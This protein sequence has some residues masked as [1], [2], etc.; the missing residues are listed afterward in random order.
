MSIEQARKKFGSQPLEPE[1]FKKGD[2]KTRGE[3][4]ADLVQ[5]RSLIGKPL[6]SIQQLLGAPDGYFENKGIPA[7]II[8]PETNKR[9]TWQ[10]VFFPDKDWKMVDEVKI[11]KNCCD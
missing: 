8:S 9:D 5:K 10:L 1:K 2:R 3:M 7:Y 11:H 4:A 6:K